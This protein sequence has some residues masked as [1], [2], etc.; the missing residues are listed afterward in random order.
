MG[1]STKGR[2]FEGSALY[3]LFLLDQYE[4]SFSATLT[5]NDLNDQPAS[6]PRT[7]RLYKAEIAYLENLESGF[8]VLTSIEDGSAGV[9]LRKVRQYFIGV[10][11]S[12]LNLGGNS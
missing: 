8:K 11:I 12:K 7:Q 10:A 4:V 9:M 2:V 1:A 6:M 5:H 3:H